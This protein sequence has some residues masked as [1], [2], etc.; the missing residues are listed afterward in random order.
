MLFRVMVKSARLLEY[1]PGH[2]TFQEDAGGV[3]EVYM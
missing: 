2:L 3:D 1:R